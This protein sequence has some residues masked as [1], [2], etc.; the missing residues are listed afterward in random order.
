MGWS[1]SSTPRSMAHAIEEF[2]RDLNVR[3]AQS[4]TIVRK[5]IRGMHVWLLIRVET[6][7]SSWYEIGLLL[8]KRGGGEWCYKLQSEFDGPCETSCPQ[9]FLDYPTQPMDPE[10]HR[11]ALEWRARIRA[12]KAQAK[13]GDLEL[14]RRYWLRPGHGWNLRGTPIEWIEVSRRRPLVVETNAGRGR[15]SPKI[16]ACLREDWRDSSPTRKAVPAGPTTRP[17]SQPSLF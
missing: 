1:C 6:R 17:L 8:L 16:L 7:E 10:R 5:A 15:T 14:G 9:S 3:G 4:T 11:Y 2:T 12:R 13:A